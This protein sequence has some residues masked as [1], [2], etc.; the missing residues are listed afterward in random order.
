M[1]QEYTELYKSKM[2]AE[3]MLFIT[4]ALILLM[5]VYFPSYFFHNAQPSFSYGV[6]PDKL[7]SI[8]ASIKREEFKAEV[9]FM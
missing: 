7:E 3:R 4:L 5:I 2:S 6:D 9:V 8:S 1:E